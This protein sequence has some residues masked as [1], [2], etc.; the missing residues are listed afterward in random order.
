VLGAIT[1]DIIG[2]RFEHHNIRTKEFQLFEPRCRFTDDT[3]HTVALAEALVSGQSYALLLKDYFRAYPEAGYGSSFRSWASGPS[4]EPYGSFG[5]GSAMRVSPVGWFFNDLAA[6]LAAARS[7]AS[8]THNHPEGIRGA[9]AV[10]AAIFLGRQQADKPCIRRTIEREFAYDLGRR[11][12]AIRPNYRFD[13]TCQGS[14]PEAI[15]AFLEATDFEDAIRNAIS[16]GGD[17]DTLAC[18]AGS[19]AEA[20]YGGVPQAIAAAVWTRLDDRLSAVVRRFL[21]ET[22]GR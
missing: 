17:S 12:D 8:V 10:A 7:S 5:N 15:I 3:V 1:G 9:Q 21:E 22:R 13:V 19:I 18:I 6:V 2:S 14:V 4:L 16:I 20:Y 11:L